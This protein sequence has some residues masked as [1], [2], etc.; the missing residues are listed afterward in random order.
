MDD[1]SDLLEIKTAIVEIRG[2]LRT[3]N[4]EMRGGDKDQAS[5]VK[6]LS[7]VVENL[8]K[9]LAEQRGDLKEALTEFRGAIRELSESITAQ[10]TG[11][12]LRLEA[13]LR[14]HE[15]DDSPHSKT[16][17]A[18]MDVLERSINRAYGGMAL[19]AALGLPG[20]AVV[21]KWFQN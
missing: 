5:G 16:L 13:H 8:A 1:M 10:A 19:L 15:F 3:L 17:G 9:N 4:A 2:E 14:E 18:R 12:S 21:V 11:V 20:V 7:Q 6:M